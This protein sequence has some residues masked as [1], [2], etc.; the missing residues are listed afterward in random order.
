MVVFSKI[1]SI[2]WLG[3]WGSVHFCQFVGS[4]AGN[5]DYA[6][7]TLPVRHELLLLAFE[8]DFP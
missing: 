7:W 6:I 4:L 8:K 3:N 5:L 2:P 1:E